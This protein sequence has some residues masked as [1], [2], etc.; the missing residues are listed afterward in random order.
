MISGI[1][2]VFGDDINTDL[3][4]PSYFFSL[5]QKTVRAGFMGELA[6]VRSRDK[7]RDRLI[8]AG[9]NFGCGSSRET[10]MTALKLAGVKAVIA[11]SFGRIFFRNAMSLG[12]PAFQV[13][14]VA[15]FAVSGD[16]LELT[17]LAVRNVG[18]GNSIQLN[19]P[20]PF[21]ADVLA[22]G[23]LLPFLSRRGEL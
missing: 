2:L 9:R 14:S 18:S 17:G 4:H 11:E 8:V 15:G 13:D 5:D 12:V 21:W 16:S 7:D 22:S 20:D 23:G 6:E 1:A 10:T 3:L 19:P